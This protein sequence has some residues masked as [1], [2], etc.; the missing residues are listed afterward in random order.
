L[1][2]FFLSE[3]LFFFIVGALCWRSAR[4]RECVMPSNPKLV[5]LRQQL[6]EKF[7]GLRTK[8][9]ELRQPDRHTWPTGIKQI[10]R[11]LENGL[12]QSAI[13]EIVADKKSSGSALFIAA[14]LRKASSEKQILALV[15]GQDSFDPTRFEN[16]MLSRLLWVRCKTAEQALKATDLILRDRNVPL[17]VLDLQ[18]NPATQLRKVPSSTWYRLQRIVEATSTIFVVI[19]PQAMVGCAQSRLNLQSRLTLEALQ[20]N[21]SDLLDKLKADL[22]QHRLHISPAEDHAATAG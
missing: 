18:L 14:L 6:A 8:A 12:H 21:E 10:D 11:L 17:L 5:Q 4:N 9:E 22:V 15:D 19:T 20:E 16:P 7:P 1:S 3:I 13:T 2:D